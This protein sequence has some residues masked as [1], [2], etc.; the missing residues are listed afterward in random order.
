MKRF[1]AILLLLLGGTK[2]YPPT[3]PIMEYSK[4]EKGRP[5]I[6]EEEEEKELWE[7]IRKWGS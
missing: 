3:H 7:F 2:G 6:D 1:I 5:E 4:D